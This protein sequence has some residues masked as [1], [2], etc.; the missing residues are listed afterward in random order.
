MK[1]FKLDAHQS[2]GELVAQDYRYAEVFKGFGIDFC[3]G[4][5]AS[6]E[7]SCIKKGVDPEALYAALDKIKHKPSAAP[8]LD[9]DK[10]ALDFLADFIENTHH[11]YVNEALPLLDQYC[12]KV[13]RVHG[14]THP[15]LI[16]IA[17]HYQ[18]VADE[19]RGHMPKEENIL[20]PAIRQMMKAIKE[21][22]PIPALPFGS[23][24]NPI[25]VMEMEHQA[26]GD[27]LKEIRRLSNNYTPPAE[28]CNTF[29]VMYANLEAFEIDLH[30]HVHLENNIL[31]PKAVLLEAQLLS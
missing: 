1:A 26:A 19:L 3:C 13:L 16:E 14:E 17:Q 9:Y 15:E 4:G 11:Q 10:W 21:Q 23:I 5:K 2:V 6:V 24:K 31:F 25:A 29:R 30:Q 8:S 7:S 18:A 12:S 28:A 20:F 22:Q 27:H